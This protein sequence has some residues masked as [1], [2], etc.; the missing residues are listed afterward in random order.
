VIVDLDHVQVAAPPGC[1]VEARRFY[2]QLLGL[3]EVDKPPRLA[4]RGG[5]WFRVGP[6]EL[7]IGVT[8]GFTP[9]TKAH[10]ALR[11][12]SRESLARLVARLEGHGLEVAW[13]D[14]DEIPGVERCFVDDPWGNRIELLA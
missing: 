11:A 3:E 4:H 9:A 12:A 14:P 5:A 13:A 1:E 6:R 2:G 10:P 7:H 8:P